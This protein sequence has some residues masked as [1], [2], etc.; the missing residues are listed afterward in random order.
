[1]FTTAGS[2][3]VQG[4]RRSVLAARVTGTQSR[5]TSSQ[6]KRTEVEEDV[7]TITSEFTNVV[8]PLSVE[9]ASK[10]EREAF[11]QDYTK[12]HNTLGSADTAYRSR[13]PADFYDKTPRQQEAFKAFADAYASVYGTV[14]DKHGDNL[15]P[16][17][18]RLAALMEYSNAQPVEPIRVCITGA[19]GHLGYA[20]AFRIASGSVFGPQTPVILSLLEVPDA[21]NRLK[22]VEMELRDA[23]FPN[24]KAII[25]TDK[26]EVAFDGVDYALLVGARP[27]SKG[28]ERGDLLMANAE[29][30]AAQGKALNSAG[31][32]DKTRVL[33]VG[34]PAN[35]NA[36]IASHHAASIPKANFSAMTRLDH[37]R[38]LAQLSQKLN[39]KVTD[40]DRF[41]IW[42]NHSATQY[43]DV[44]HA[45]I[46]GKWALDLIKEKNWLESDFYPTVQKRGAAIIEARGL[47]SAASAASAA[48]DAVAD[49]HFG[50][51]G[52][53]TSA[54]V[55]SKGE[56]GVTEGLFYSYPVV[57]NS[58]KEWDIV[59]DLP[60]TEAS[61]KYMEATHQELLQERDDV[62]ALLK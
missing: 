5:C 37:N 25:S 8:Q 61:A 11:V 54:G 9:E 4:G 59:R 43:P 38:G 50:T 28:M 30:F 15:N 1:M 21:L 56:Y 42:G 32:G 57:Y 23:A 41:V 36:L 62:A 20:L 12:F 35:T 22:G 17:L 6:Q 40:I 3:L 60:I 34:N 47:S 13:F 10:K 53:W 26:P 7:A 29:I 52:Q 58:S 24:I 46:N 45:K 14:L 39:V 55:V 27:R 19:A 2:K 51:N 18:G 48:C 33:V 16:G 31:K 44:S 49:W